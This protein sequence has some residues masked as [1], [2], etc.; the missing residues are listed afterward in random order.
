MKKLIAALLAVVLLCAA[1]SALASDNVKFKSSAYVY[2]TAGAERTGVVIRK[3]S[4]AQ[5]VDQAGGWAQIKYG[6]SLGWVRVNCIKVTDDAVKVVYSATP[7]PE[8]QEEAAAPAA[9]FPS[10]FAVQDM[11]ASTVKTLH[12][13]WGQR[14]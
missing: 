13:M 12:R 5:Y 9:L 14:Q 3:G 6:K 8:P 1:G 7:A 10:G 2:A 11:I 4:V